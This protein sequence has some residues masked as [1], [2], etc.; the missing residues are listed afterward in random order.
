MQI[1]LNI[2]Q[3]RADTP[4]PPIFRVR[5]RWQTMP[6]TDVTATVRAEL[7]RLGLA[8]RIRPGMQI[9]VT[10]GS[11]GITNIVQITAAA[12]GCSSYG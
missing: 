1:T 2:E 7:D 6:L 10:A 3:I 4:L 5:Q 8:A 12:V 9:A 11:R